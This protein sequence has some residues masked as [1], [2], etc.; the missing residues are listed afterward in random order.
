MKTCFSYVFWGLVFV[1]FDLSINGFDVLP[2]GLGYVLAAIGCGGLISLSYRFSI[3]RSL[4]WLLALLWL[5]GFSSMSRDAATIFGVVTTVV[6]CVMLW[7]L[8]G[9]ILEFAVSQNRLDLAIRASNRRLA[10]V[11]LTIFITAAGLIAHELRDIAGPLIV[12]TVVAILAVMVMIL[13][14]IYRVRSELA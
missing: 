2:D 5:V 13:H 4:C 1:C 6:R 12:V 9:G 7:M 14:L 3:A 11:A 8:L 10:Y